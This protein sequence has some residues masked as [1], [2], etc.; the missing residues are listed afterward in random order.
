MSGSVN[1]G[2]NGTSPPSKEDLERLLARLD[3]RLREVLVL[4][5]GID[6]GK[7]RTLEELAE[8]LG[9]STERVD[10]LV[11]QAMRELRKEEL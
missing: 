8:R 5:F 3:V 9:L 1:E 4:R 2:A 6:R 11:Q 7:P 10:Q